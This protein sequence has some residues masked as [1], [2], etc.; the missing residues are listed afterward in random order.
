MQGSTERVLWVLACFLGVWSQSET[1]L[2][3]KQS[4]TPCI[5]SISPIYSSMRQ[6]GLTAAGSGCLADVSQ[7]IRTAHLCN[8]RRASQF[9]TIQKACHALCISTVRYCKLKANI[10]KGESGLLCLTP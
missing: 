9:S 4:A 2:V 6:F 1:G 8:N 5:N 10:C 7:L 3:K